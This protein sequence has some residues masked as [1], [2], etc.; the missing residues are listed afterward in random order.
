MGVKRLTNRYGEVGYGQ[1][2]V[3]DSVLVYPED[4]AVGVGRVIQRR[5]EV[6]EG[7]AGVV[8][9]L[10][11][12]RL[13]LCFCQGPHLD[14]TAADE[15]CSFGVRMKSA[16]GKRVRLAKRE[17]RYSLADKIRPT[18]LYPRGAGITASSAISSA[19]VMHVHVPS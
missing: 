2:H 14:C 16:D 1:A 10:L 19:P 7:V 15:C 4:I 11:E 9:Q 5:D 8:R 12:K 13:R 17:K 3:V 18:H 6:L